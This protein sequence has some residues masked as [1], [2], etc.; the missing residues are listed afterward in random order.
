[1]IYDSITRAP[2]KQRDKKVKKFDHLR[3]HDKENYLTNMQDYMWL[4]KTRHR[5][6]EDML[7]YEVTNVYVLRSTGDIVGSRSLV[8]KDGSLF[9]KEEYDPIH[10]RDLVILT[11][12]YTKEREEQLQCNYVTDCWAEEPNSTLS[13]SDGRVDRIPEKLAS[14]YTQLC[15][16]YDQS[17][18]LLEYCLMALSSKEKIPTPNTRR[19]AM[20]SKQRDNWLAAE[21]KETE[22]ITKKEVLESAVLPQG[23][24]L[25]KTKWVYKLKHSK[26]V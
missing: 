25:L 6:D 16:Q 21:Q 8:M 22:S 13:D 18:H 19:Q 12:R 26:Y 2:K 11:N 17:D 23:K 1:V 15:Q 24:R 3:S 7:V 9:T 10:V 4:V 20:A 5:D 14:I